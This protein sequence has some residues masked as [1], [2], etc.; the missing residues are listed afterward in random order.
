LIE[1]AA[2]AV[3]VLI[4]LKDLNKL[5]TVTALRA[6]GTLRL[7]NWLTVEDQL[8]EALL[9]I[10][11]ATGLSEAAALEFN[12]SSDAASTI[13]MHRFAESS[14]WEGLA[15]VTL[16]AT[17]RSREAAVRAADLWGVG[18]GSIS[19]LYALLVSPNSSGALQWV[20][21]QFLSTEPIQ[22]LAVTWGG[23]SQTPGEGE[24]HTLQEPAAQEEATSLAAAAK[25]RPEL[26]KLLETPEKLLLQSSVTS[27]LRVS[28][29]YITLCTSSSI[30]TSLIF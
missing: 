25:L 7:S 1:L 10:L 20:A 27:A 12:A 28:G 26:A 19:A 16:E 17:N 29:H 18:K 23:V 8:M 3:S 24:E 11:F 5:E 22:T 4:L 21:F 30:T 2:T 9:R 14:L 15:T 6:Q 13:S